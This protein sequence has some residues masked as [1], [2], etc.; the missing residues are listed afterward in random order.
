MPSAENDA[1]YARV[2]VDDLPR[3]GKNAIFFSY[4]P[5]YSLCL[6]YSLCLVTE[7]KGA[8]GAKG[9]SKFIGSFLS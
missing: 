1:L 8:K 3:V 4:S 7:G 2:C 9:G 6:L 5:Y